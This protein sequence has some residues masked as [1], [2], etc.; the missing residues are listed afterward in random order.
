M[1]MGWRPTRCQYGQLWL[2]I[3]DLSNVGYKDDPWVLGNRVAHVFYAQDL[4]IENKKAEKEKHV[5]VSRKQQIVGVDGVLDL[6]DFN[7]FSEMPLFY[8]PTWEDK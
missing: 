1:P 8:R 6:E 4:S 3:V 7:Q 2:R 5:V